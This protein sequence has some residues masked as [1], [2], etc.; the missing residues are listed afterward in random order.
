M[1]SVSKMSESSYKTFIIDKKILKTICTKSSNIE[2]YNNPKE[3]FKNTYFPNGYIDMI[4]SS[5]L[6][7]K[8]LHGK[9]VI[10]YV[11]KEETKDIDDLRDL[12]YVKL[13]ISKSKIYKN[14]FAN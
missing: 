13:L 14:L 9:K 11:I 10:P 2:K 12:K 7:N 1:R 8:I 4:K 3:L 6:K 5:N